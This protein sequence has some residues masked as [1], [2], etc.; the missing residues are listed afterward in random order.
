[1]GETDAAPTG[2]AVRE[3]I[4]RIVAERDIISVYQP[5]VELRTGDVVGCEILSR[6]PV[7][8]P[9][10]APGPLFAAAAAAGLL[11][12]LDIVCRVLGL[13]RAR[14][15][16][17]D[18]QL[19][20]VNVEPGSGHDLSMSREL[21]DVLH[22]VPFQIV[23]EF[24]ERTLTH[25]AANLLRYADGIHDRGNLIAIDDLGADPHSLALVPLLQPDILKLDISVTQGSSTRAGA[26]AAAAWEYA[27][28]RGA[29]VL[30][31]G[32]ETEEHRERALALGAT[33]GQ[34]F[35]FGRPG[36]A[37]AV[38]SRRRAD[39]VLPWS[40]VPRA[41]DSGSPAPASRPASRLML[42]LLSR[43]LE[44]Q[45]RQ[46][47]QHAV[48]L[49][50]VEDAA[51]L[52]RGVVD[53]YAA[54]A[55][56]AALVG[57]VGLG[58]PERP[59]P[60]VQGGPLAAGDELAGA[61]VVAVVGPHSGGALTAVRADRGDGYDAVVTNDRAQAS[62][63]AER[64]ARRLAPY[65]PENPIVRWPAVTVPPQARESATDLARLGP[66]AGP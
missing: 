6:G 17:G 20:F 1:M 8:S 28:A 53:R 31:E 12:E 13:S 56:H 43:Q 38:T 19:V 33:W 4:A 61:W 42:S 64:L 21:L 16:P 3:E 30:A 9:L 2:P 11:T 59:A 66:H 7:G 62:R 39:V 5:I 29:V 65:T 10:H 41:P 37:A 35:L 52:T 18:L 44:E 45:A 49:A 50:A 58:M 57:I 63:V 51:V 48:L 54:V 23:V 22:S 40:G 26:T 46:L 27:H 34:G 47:G 55:E 32:I 60:G 24:T 15:A 36:P 14:D 25:R